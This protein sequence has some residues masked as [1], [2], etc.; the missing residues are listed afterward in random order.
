MTAA[1][2]YGHAEAFCLMTYRAD[3]GEEEVVW[4][5]RDSVT[6]FVITLRS[7]KEAQHVNW[8]HDTRVPDYTPP[9]GTRMFVDL[10]AEAAQRHAAANAARFFADDHEYSLMARQRYGT[11]EAMAA[12]L[13]A[14]YLRPGAP[15]LVEVP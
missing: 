14:E 12:E 7:G 4:N 5:S 8:S 11:V 15:D 9:T 3:D 2:P 13:A 1:A 10:T 6:P